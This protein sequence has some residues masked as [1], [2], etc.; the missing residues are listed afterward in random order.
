M[1]KAAHSYIVSKTDNRIVFLPTLGQI[2]LAIHNHT[3]LLCILLLMYSPYIEVKSL[4]FVDAGIRL[5]IT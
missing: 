2:S 5:F 4:K 1:C 3:N